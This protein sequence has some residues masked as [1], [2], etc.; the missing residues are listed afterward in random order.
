MGVTVREKPKGSGVWW[1]FISQAGQRRS[2]RVG[3]GTRGRKLAEDVAVKIRARL[4]E[5]DRSIL[6]PSPEPEVAPLF[7]EAAQQWLARYRS[8]FGVRDST[9]AN[10]RLFI[11]RHLAPF[12]AGRRASAITTELVEDFI[13]AKRATGGSKRGKA[14]ADSTLKV[15][16]PTLRMILD[17][18]VRRQWMTSNPPRGEPLWRPTPRSTQPDPFTQPELAA[19]VMAATVIA[20]AWG[21]MVRAWAQSGMRSGELR[22]LQGQDVDPR[23]G[24]VSIQRTRSQRATGPTKTLRSVRLAA[25]TH[26]TCEPTAAWEPGATPESLTVVTRLALLVHLDPSAPLFGSLKHPGR[27]MDERELH[28]LWRRTLARAK[29]RP[30]PPETL[31]HSCISILLSRNAPLLAVAAQTGHSAKVMLQDYAR[32]LPQAHLAAPPAHPRGVEATG[33]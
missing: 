3:V 1:V 14:M 16:L 8:L 22:G 5:G 28:T 29:V 30:R 32:W 27:P 9:L 23:T 4:L 18:C 6:T 31:R 20:P 24:L 26:P 7:A 21:L 15:N 33:K 11:E 25:L 2:K 13:A 10:R 17:Y 12:F 19:L